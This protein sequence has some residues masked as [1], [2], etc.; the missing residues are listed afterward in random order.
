MAEIIRQDRDIECQLS[1]FVSQSHNFEMRICQVTNLGKRARRL[2]LTSY[3]EWVLGS[4]EA[5]RNHP[6]FSKLFVETQFC[7][8][9]RAILARR[10]PR[11]SEESQFWGFHSVLC[12]GMPVSRKE[13]Q[14]ETN[15]M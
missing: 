8:E 1:V 14:F 6:A 4:Q 12:D 3:L 5:D 13:L 10:R 9:L 15:R 2:E 7:S 11:H